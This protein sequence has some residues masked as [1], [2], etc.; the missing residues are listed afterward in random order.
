MQRTRTNDLINLSK[1]EKVVNERHQF[2]QKLLN[3]SPLTV[4]HRFN[5]KGRTVSTVTFENKVSL[6]EILDCN[7]KIEKEC[8]TRINDCRLITLGKI[9][10]VYVYVI[11]EVYEIETITNE[12]INSDY[13]YM[14]CDN[15]I[16]ETMIN[17]TYVYEHTDKLYVSSISIDHND[18]DYWYEVGIGGKGSD[19]D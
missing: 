11:G 13:L 10:E 17:K 5:E 19:S 1:D 9:E 14:R 8:V 18:P 12:N 16:N 3:I 2:I 6:Q 4:S 15:L 7:D